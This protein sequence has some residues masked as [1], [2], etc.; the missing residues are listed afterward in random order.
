MI[1]KYWKDHQDKRERERN[2]LEKE[3]ERERK[4]LEMQI[5]LNQ[6]EL[7]LQNKFLGEI[8]ECVMGIIVAI[9]RVEECLH[10]LQRNQKNSN[11]KEYP[12]LD[13]LDKFIETRDKVYEDFLVKSHVLQSEIQA[14]FGNKCLPKWNT[15]MDLI[16]F[17][18]HLSE[19]KDP[20]ERRDYIDGRLN[21]YEPLE[22]EY[23]PLE[24]ENIFKK[25]LDDAEG[26]Y[27]NHRLAKEHSEKV[28]ITD[29]LSEMDIE[30]WYQVKHAIVDR[31]DELNKTILETQI[32]QFHPAMKNML[33]V[34]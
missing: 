3:R 29:K 2:R 33:K 23:E 6:K 14:Y 20:K 18:E 5:E 1:A 15:L 9:M 13:D 34:T 16:K 10:G 22:R 28:K 25:L 19:R 7:E 24:R 30:A 31:K 27:R 4:D 8:S 32:S 17:V 11:G 26:K 12:R 21:E